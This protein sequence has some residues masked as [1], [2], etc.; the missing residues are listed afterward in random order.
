VQWDTFGN[1]SEGASTAGS[2]V[3]N[4]IPGG[5]NVLYMDGHAEFIRY[6]TRFPLV[7]DAGILRENGHFGLY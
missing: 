4:H 6:P 3:F 2:A 7:E 5:S 1:P